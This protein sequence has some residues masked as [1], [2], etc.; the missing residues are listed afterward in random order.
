MLKI[1]SFREKFLM[2]SVE[3]ECPLLW[4]GTPNNDDVETPKVGVVPR[5]T[6]HR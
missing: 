1:L 3:R 5:P 6:G 4:V 2:D